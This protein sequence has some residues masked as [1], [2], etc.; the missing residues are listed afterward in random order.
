M[1]LDAKAPLNSNFELGEDLANHR[2]SVTKL[3]ADSYL[4]YYKRLYIYEQPPGIIIIIDR[5]TE[6]LDYLLE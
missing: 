4:A 6:I 2:Y 3:S 1:E 5:S